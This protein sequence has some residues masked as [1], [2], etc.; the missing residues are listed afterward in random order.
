MEKLNFKKITV[1][2]PGEKELV[3]FIED[4]KNEEL[5]ASRKETVKEIIENYR[6]IASL[7]I[8]TVFKKVYLDTKTERLQM[9]LIEHSIGR[10][11][12]NMIKLGASINGF[13]ENGTTEKEIELIESIFNKFY[14]VRDVF[15]G[16][17][18]E[19]A[20]LTIPVLIDTLESVLSTEEETEI[21]TGNKK[22][23]LKTGIGRAVSML[24]ELSVLMGFDG[25]DILNT[26]ITS[27]EINHLEREKANDLAEDER[28]AI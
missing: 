3:K 17:G 11:L 21:D 8:E 19:H 15:D 20:T 14:C 13:F 12:G 6:T 23:L 7:T 18:I 28:L 9:E 27:L 4:I 5:K 1:D 25:E 2:R 22:I 26:A 16:L 24:A 10:A